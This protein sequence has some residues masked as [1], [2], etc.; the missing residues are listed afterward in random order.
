M[1][2]PAPLKKGDKIAIVS[3][4]RKIS[5]KEIQP[6]LKL[7]KEWGLEPILGKN[8]FAEYDQF[9]GTDEQRLEDL[10]ESINNPDVKAIICARGGYGTVKIIDD[11]N[12]FT[13]IAHPKWIIGY[14]DVSVLLNKLSNM[15]IESLHATMPINFKENTEKSLKSLKRALF[16][17]KTLEYEVKPHPFNRFGEVRSRLVGGNLSMLYSQLGSETALKTD[18]K[19]LFIEDLDEYLYHIDRMMLALKRAGYFNK[20]AGLVVGSMNQ[21][22]DNKTPF[23]KDAYQIIKDVVAPY[24]FPVAFNFPA[25]HINDNRTLIFGRKATLS[26]EENMTSLKFD[27]GP[28]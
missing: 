15:N 16:A 24:N 14:S 28:A 23:G 3:T 5:E 11:V 8:L 9:A 2:T 6:A 12:F 21:M 13:L 26:I 27:H 7:F 25:G 17:N 22:N 4:A 18:G 1:I 10:Q 20:L 19:I